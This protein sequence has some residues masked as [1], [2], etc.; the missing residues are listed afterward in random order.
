MKIIRTFHQPYEPLSQNRFCH[1]YIVAIDP[2]VDKNGVATLNPQTRLLETA[3]MAFPALLDYLQQTA[4]VC[5]ESRK[6]LIVIVEAGWLNRSNWHTDSTQSY[7]VAAKIGS[8]TGANGEVGKKIVEMC[9]HY[10]IEVVEQKP[11]RKCWTGSEGKITH[12]ELAAFTQI[13]GRTNQEER[14]A[15][16][17]AWCYAELPIIVK[18][19]TK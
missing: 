1:D 6:S 10:G 7:R 5:Y 12:A 17:L 8:H 9:R 19:I 11:L 2:D 18:N 4:K 13:K 16:L 3:Q 14:D 15:A